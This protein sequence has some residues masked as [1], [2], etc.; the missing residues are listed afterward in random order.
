MTR[1]FRKAKEHR[2]QWQL[3]RSYHFTRTP[4]RIAAQFNWH[5]NCTTMGDSWYITQ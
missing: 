4:G 2:V 3:N 5:G 1:Y